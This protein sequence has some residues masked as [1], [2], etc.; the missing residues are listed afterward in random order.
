VQTSRALKREVKKQSQHDR[1]R[2]GL[3]AGP[4]TSRLRRPS[5][6]DGMLIP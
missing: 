4:S 5:S 2:W 6:E 3:N 1:L